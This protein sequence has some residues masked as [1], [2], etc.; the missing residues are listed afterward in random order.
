MTTGNQRTVILFMVDQLAA[1]WLEAARH[2]I[3]DLPNFDALQ[4][5]GVTFS[6]AFSTNPVCSPSRASIITGMSNSA[7][8]VTECGYDLSPDV[9]NIAQ[10]LQDNGWSTGAFGKLHLV[11]QIETLT[12]DY[13]A[14]G[15]DVVNNTEDARAGEW[16]DWVKQYHPEY[17]KAALSTVWMT[18]VPELEKYG[19]EGEDLRSLIHEAQREYPDSVSDAYELPFP[20]DVSQTAWI[21]D[22][23]LGFIERTDGDLFAHISYVQPHNP[24][25][26][27]AEFVDRVNVDA[28]PEPTGAEWKTH[29]IPYFQQER[30][31][32][33]SYD[34]DDW[35][36]QRQLYFADLS[37]LDHELGR[38]RNALSEAGRADDALFIFT[39]DHG[40]MLHDQGLLGKWERHYDPCIRIPL[41]VS[42]TASGAGE[43]SERHELVEHTD[44]AATIYDWARIPE[45]M[46]AT[47]EP[48]I[49][50]I[51]MLHGRSLLPRTT[52]DGESWR[53]CILI[54]SNNSHFD[55][56]PS[57]WARTIRTERYRYT[58]YLAGG[59][60]QLFDV[61]RDPDEQWNL[62]FDPEFSGVKAKLA[63][64]LMELT[65]N[66]GYP[67]SPRGLFSIGTW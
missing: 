27:P 41:I 31:E 21:T 6:S 52:D 19:A 28:I 33:P 50:P 26:P 58:R 64:E 59:G 36:R 30:Y 14:Y 61:L 67:N 12:P 43:Q 44:I 37:H 4:K 29:P 47:F 1:R 25:A 3:V 42:D 63:D 8:G 5:D 48:R 55:A 23:A 9:P 18:M 11:T 60:E 17:Y 57:S 22:R 66:D 53:D 20:A 49:D 39:S 62:A 15:F 54:Q 40:E 10:A 35:R 56:S 24:F 13:H 65:V 7:H 32:T 46:L 16:L 2:G 45:P 38:V 34:V 51:R